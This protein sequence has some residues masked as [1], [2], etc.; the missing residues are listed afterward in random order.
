MTLFRKERKVIAD[1]TEAVK[2]GS[3][4]VKTALIVIGA[5]AV[6]ALVI[7]VMK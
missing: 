4:T 6:A 5:I 3:N 2:D 7:A 1:A